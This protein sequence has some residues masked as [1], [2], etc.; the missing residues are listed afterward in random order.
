MLLF[1][2]QKKETLGCKVRFGEVNHQSGALTLLPDHV[3]ASEV[4]QAK[5]EFIFEDIVNLHATFQVKM[6]KTHRGC[7]ELPPGRIS[8]SAPLYL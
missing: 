5:S 7:F 1:L 2:W 3:L 4:Q 6:R 8:F